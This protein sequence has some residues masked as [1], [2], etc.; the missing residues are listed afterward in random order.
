MERAGYGNGSNCPCLRD[1]EPKLTCVCVFS[2][3][4]KKSTLQS[5]NQIGQTFRAFLPFPTTPT[6]GMIMMTPI[7]MD[8]IATPDSLV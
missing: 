3:K 7:A 4:T 5:T 6:R 8:L 2:Q 1:F